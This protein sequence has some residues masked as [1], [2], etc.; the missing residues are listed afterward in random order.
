MAN[1]K[2]Q[3]NIKEEYKNIWKY[4]RESKNFIYFSIIIFFV[5]FL[6]A[7][8]F[9]ASG[10][11]L[12]YILELITDL[13]EK[14]SKLSGFEL[15]LFILLN[16]LSSSFFGMIFGF[17]LGVFPF[18]ALLLN[19]YVLGFVSSLSIAENGFSSLWRILPHGIFELPAIFLALGIGLRLGSFVFQKKG[20]DK[21]RYL[22]VNSIKTFLL[23]V[24]P[25]LLIAAI[26]EGT[27]IFIFGN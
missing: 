18:L 22:F 13:L 14:T 3:F 27:L 20:I 19:G 4:L 25:L 16:N 6:L 7:F 11:L 24:L 5:S 21:F 12:N 23:I 15:I 17:F 9:P 1:R 8:I 2:K 10:N 26:I